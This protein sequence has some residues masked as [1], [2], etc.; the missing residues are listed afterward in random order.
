MNKFLFITAVFNLIFL[1]ASRSVSAQT[2]TEPNFKVAFIGD[3]GA[4][5]GFQSILNL[6]KAEG[7]QM[8]LHQG[9]FDYS[10]GPQVWMDK[11]NATL[12]AN[13]PYLGSDGNH[14]IWDTDGY[15]AFFKDRLTKMGL[16]APAGNLPTNYSTVYKGLK[17]VFVQENGNPSYIAQ[18]LGNDNHVWKI[19]S[20]HKNVTNLQLG[21][22]SND[23]GYPDYE[24]CRQYGAIIATAHEHTY[25]RTKTFAN[26]ANSIQNLAIDTT[27]HP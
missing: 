14:D 7:A 3:S 1:T 8:V 24:T 19:C 13:F 25:E 17:M 18:E 21:T 16:T 12:G 2:S 9:D 15:G 27:L 10:A 22:K 5:N 26:T 4:G 6:I 23:Q 20:W 11:I